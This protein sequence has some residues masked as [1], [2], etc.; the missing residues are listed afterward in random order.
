MIF[1]F[2]Q[3]GPVDY[4]FGPESPLYLANLPS[5]FNKRKATNS[6]AGSLFQ[7]SFGQKYYILPNFRGK[8]GSSQLYFQKGHFVCTSQFQSACGAIFLS[9]V[10]KLGKSLS[11]GL[12]FWGPRLTA[13]LERGPYCLRVEMKLS[14]SQD[15]SKCIS[16]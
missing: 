8:A 16:R 2:Q 13:G 12:L 9:R 4:F 6:R 5:N 14:S 11:Y 10:S 3:A 7:N 15:T 1:D